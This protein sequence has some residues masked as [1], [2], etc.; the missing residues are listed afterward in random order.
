MSN[1]ISAVPAALPADLLA[2]AS[3]GSPTVS[4][5]PQATVRRTNSVSST[6]SGRAPLIP[7]KV[8]QS[9]IRNQF[10]GGSQTAPDGWDITP[11]DKTNFDALFRGIDTGNKGFID[12]IPFFTLLT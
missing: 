9:P 10:T 5:F 6:G 1:H 2:A 7:P 3:L 4:Q 12:G 8:T 11:Q